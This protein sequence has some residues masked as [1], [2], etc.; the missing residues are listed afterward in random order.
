LFPKINRRAPG[1]SPE[2]LELNPN[3]QAPVLD[4]DG[5]MSQR[6]LWVVNEVEHLLITIL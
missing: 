6:S 3:G 1:G 4:D 5:S 2:F